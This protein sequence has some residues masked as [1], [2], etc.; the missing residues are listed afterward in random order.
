MIRETG[1]MGGLEGW[2]LGAEE[3]R[4]MGPGICPREWDIVLEKNGFSGVDCIAHDH[5]DVA[6][7]SCSVFA[8]QAV[9][10]RLQVLRDPLFSM[11]LIPQSPILILGGKTLAVSKLARRAA[12]MLRL[13]SP[14]IRTCD[15]IDDLDSSEMLP[16][17]F[18]LCLSDLDKPFFAEP[19]TP[20][21]LDKLQ[22]MLG[23]A[24]NILWVTCGRM[25]DDPYVNMMVGIGRAL[26]VE[27]PHVNMHYLDFDRPEAWDADVIVRHVLRMAVT[28]ASST[29]TQGMLWA[30]EPE[31]LIRGNEMLVPRIVPDDAANETLNA[32][33]RRISKLVDS[34]ERVD[35]VSDGS[36]SSQPQ[37]VTGGGGGA[38]SIPEGHVAPASAG[39][40]FALS[41]TD[42]STVVAHANSL[43]ECSDAQADNAE[44]LVATASALIASQVL[45]SFPQHGTTLVCG[46]TASMADAISAAAAEAGRKVLF[47]TVDSAGKGG[48]DG[49]I[50]VH[51]RASARVVQRLIPRDTLLVLNLSKDGLGN[52]LACLPKLCIVQAFDP[53]C[54]P[55][56]PAAE[57]AA[58]L[59]RAYDTCKTR[60]SKRTSTASVTVLNIT[61]ASQELLAQ[62]D[63]LSPVLDWE[64]H[65]PVSA[66]V[67][68]LEASSIFSVDKTYFLVGMAGELGQSLCRFMIRGGARYI[69]LA[70]R[71]PAQDPHWLTDLRSTGADV[72]IVKMDVTD[73]TQ[74][75]ETVAMLRQTMPEM[76][77]VANAALVFEAGIFV[78]FSADNVARQLKPK[79][80]GTLH[81]DK[82]FAT[83]NLEFFLTFGSLA[84][85][86]GNP[87]QAMYHVGNMFMSSLV[88]RRRRRGQAASILNFGLLVD[89][90]YVARMDR[91]DGTDIEG[92]LRSLLLTPLS[93]AE[94]HHLVLQGIMSGRPGS[95]SREVIM[96]MAPYIDD[97]KA[98]ARP[99]WVDKAFFSHMIHAPVAT[100]KG[101]ASTQTSPSLTLQ[102]LRDNLD[103]ASTIEQVT[104]G[105][106][107]LL[108]KKIEH[109]IKVPGASIDANAPLA[110]L[111]LDSL[112]GID[113]RKWLLEE[114]KINIP[115]LRILGREPLSSLCGSIAQSFMESRGGSSDQPEAPVPAAEPTST[116]N[117]AAPEIQ[118]FSDSSLDGSKMSSPD[119]SVGRARDSEG[120]SS[121]TSPG[122]PTSSMDEP[123]WT[124]SSSFGRDVRTIHAVEHGCSRDIE[125]IAAA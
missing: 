116:A 74:V 48:R 18:V 47:V 81:L 121:L 105:V 97:G 7:H 4:R 86:C 42:S 55:C 9:D 123:L 117:T 120:E 15:S 1:L 84:T 73:Q 69:V 63:R 90:G 33:R 124:D 94:L 61:K 99:P 44:T 77:G 79:V 78:N 35:M 59:A 125:Q 83:D 41:A 109:M 89:V 101:Q 100:A 104:E 24:R 108:Y 91:A 98:A 26:A 8:S 66:V 93:E 96:G 45:P 2:W 53:G 62:R 52:V 111:G 32:K 107:E 3:G 102:H 70:S 37:L 22:G 19:P 27:L 56:Q 65:E 60:T 16:G 67:R 68:P 72:R 14:E 23:A 57:A 31:T 6:R 40:V 95:A 88:E 115:L 92:T 38:L 82:A 112:H 119:I 71:N 113:I 28:L 30:Q 50:V 17:T 75:R 29:D 13:W 103:R 36:E 118:V 49:W 80:D 25:L 10:D 21:R 11:A 20:E 122:T 76:G 46:A 110:D 58:A 34:T 39:A 5:L 51:A 87:G 106:K 114:L 85:V 54:L 43:L 64:R 12:K